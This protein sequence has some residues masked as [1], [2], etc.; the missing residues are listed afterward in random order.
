M[1]RSGN[2]DNADG[3]ECIHAYGCDREIFPPLRLRSNFGGALL[4]LRMSL[5]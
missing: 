5:K 1:S 2:R 3:Y 4:N